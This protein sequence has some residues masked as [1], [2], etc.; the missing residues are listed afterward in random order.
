METLTLKPTGLKQKFEELLGEGRMYEALELAKGNPG[1]LRTLISLTYD[2]SGVTSWRAMQT[3]GDMT[4][5]LPSDKVRNIIQR[6]LWMMREESGTNPWSAAEIISE[7][8]RAEAEP[9]KDIVPIVVMFHDEP[10]LRQ[11]SLWCLHRLGQVR[12][13]L[14][15]PYVEVAREYL[16]AQRPVD[17]GAALLAIGT[18]RDRAS[19]THVRG[20]LNDNAGFSYYDGAQMVDATIG[21]VAAM[22]LQSLGE[23]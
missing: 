14:V 15:E 9:F 12:P 2:K 4:V 1:A 22:A 3:I 19:D 20:L 13:E 17:R 23:R 11:G 16:H 5:G 10:L 8:L 6:M 7:I 21:Q 18:L